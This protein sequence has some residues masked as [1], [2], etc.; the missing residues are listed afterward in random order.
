M[1]RLTIA[2]GKIMPCKNDFVSL[3]SST[4]RTGFL[5]SSFSFFAKYPPLPT[6]FAA[7]PWEQTI[8]RASFASIIFFISTRSETLFLSDSLYIRLKISTSLCL[9]SPAET[10]PWQAE[11]SNPDF[12]HISQIGDF[13]VIIRSFVYKQEFIL[14]N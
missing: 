11:Q 10:F 9:S 6:I 2:P 3:D 5:R 1:F 7:L 4:T 12:K 8:N 13:I 14:F